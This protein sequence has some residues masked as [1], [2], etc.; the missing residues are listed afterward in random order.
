MNDET[1]RADGAFAA[2][3]NSGSEPLAQWILRLMREPHTSS[4]PAPKPPG[5]GG[6]LAIQLN[7]EGHHQ[8]FQQLPDFVTALLLQQDERAA[9]RYAPLLYHLVGCD[10]CHQAYLEI[11]DA[12]RAALSH[13]DEPI[14]CPEDGTPPGR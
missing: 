13:Q 8:F 7:A 10:R 6:M 9:L 5:D 1:L 3:A 11:Y 12:M 4:S 14:A 2:P